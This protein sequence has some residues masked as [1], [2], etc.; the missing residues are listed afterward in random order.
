MNFVADGDSDSADL[1][2]FGHDFKKIGGEKG[3]EE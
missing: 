1:T 3:P 2:N